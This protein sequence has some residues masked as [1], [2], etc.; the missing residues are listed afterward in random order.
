MLSRLFKRLGR[1]DSGSQRGAI[2]LEALAAIAVTATAG[3][4]S[5]MLISV[6]SISSSSS[7]NES[8][9]T[10]L[11][12]SQA[13]KIAGS[14]YVLTPGE[15]AGISTPTGFTVSNSTANIPG[16][17]AAIQLVTV[18]VVKDGVEILTIELV[19]VDR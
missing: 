13:E 7:T 15:Y 9:A 14:T 6:A 18:E 19:K 1:T 2:M 17:D 8:T 4:A 5:L 10:W 12:S 3:T 16:G 11:A